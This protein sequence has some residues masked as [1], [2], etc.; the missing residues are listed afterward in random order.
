MYLVEDVQFYGGAYFGYQVISRL[1]ADVQVGNAL[2]EGCPFRGVPFLV[3]GGVHVA[4]VFAC[5]PACKNETVTLD[6]AREQCAWDGI[7]I[8][9]P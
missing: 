4:Y 3:S 7:V 8:V 6:D 1:G 9:K 5:T 2:K